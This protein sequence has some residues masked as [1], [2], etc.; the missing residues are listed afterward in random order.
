MQQTY[1]VGDLTLALERLN[2]DVYS[3]YEDLA[4]TGQKASTESE[5]KRLSRLE[6]LACDINPLLLLDLND[7][8]NLITEYKKLHHISDIQLQIMKHNRYNP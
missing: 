5:E 4:K 8:R 2:D 1:P 6:R 3:L 7:T